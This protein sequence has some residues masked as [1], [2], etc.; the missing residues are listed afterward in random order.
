MDVLLGILIP[1]GNFE[2]IICYLKLLHK[3]VERARVE[4]FG[5]TP[6]FLWFALTGSYLR[7]DGKL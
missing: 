7:G 5:L 4:K 3:S 6:Y 1:S 2:F